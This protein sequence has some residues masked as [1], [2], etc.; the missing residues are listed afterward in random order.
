MA[1]LW[2]GRVPGGGLDLG[3]RWPDPGETRYQ[4]ERDH[5][6]GLEHA[7]LLGSR[8]RKASALSLVIGL[9]ASER[10]KGRG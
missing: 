1:T 5:R 9:K 7:V 2:S 4:M 8:V 6:E 3:E 10:A